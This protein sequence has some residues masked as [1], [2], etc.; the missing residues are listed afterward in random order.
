MK[1][2]ALRLIRKNSC[3][4]TFEENI[5]NCGTRSEIKILFLSCER[6]NEN[7][8]RLHFNLTFFNI[9]INL[10][11]RDSATSCSVETNKSGH[12]KKS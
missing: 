4:V 9:F 11:F 1:G 2:D 12:S 7:T 10:L 3:R 5:K 8:E 6:V